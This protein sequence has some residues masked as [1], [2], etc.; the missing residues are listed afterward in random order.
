[1][2]CAR[3][4]CPNEARPNAKYCSTDCRWKTSNE[5]RMSPSSDRK[6]RLTRLDA[7]LTESGINAE[8]IGEVVKAVR[9]SEWQ[10]MSKDADGDPQ[11]TDLKATSIL[12]HPTWATGPKW[13]VVQPAAPVMV[14]VPK[15]DH[16][17]KGALVGTWKTALIVPDTQYGFRRD[18][19][20]PTV[21]DPFHDERALDVVKQVAEA[22]RPDLSIFLGDTLDFAQ[23]GKYRQE[24]AFVLTVQPTLNAA[25]TD[26]ATINEL[27]GE[28]RVIEGNHDLRLQNQTMDNNKAAFGIKRAGAP[29]EEWPVQS[30]P[31]L[32]RLDEMGIEYVGGY[33]AG[34][35]Y[36]NDNLACIHGKKVGNV[37]R[38][39][40]SMVVEDERVSVIF[41]HTHHHETRGRTRNSRGGPKFSIAHSPGCLCR[42][43]GAVPSTKGAIDAFGRAVRSW[44]D[45]QQ[46]C[47]IVRYQPGDGRFDIEQVEIFEGWAL[48]GGQEFIS[49]VIPSWSQAV[50]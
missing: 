29:P 10:V 9:V 15:R 20:D 31:H 48:H 24:E 16:S 23:F 32:L 2:P 7:L 34:A 33:P 37:T 25:Y 42:I 35:T 4:G 13:P 3:S 45:W 5:R 11:V 36:I 12:L 27:S 40:A 14:K 21:M 38:S 18:L 50:A 22:E 28:T 43:D 30:I 17:G 6:S 44:E 47:S 19:Y 49:R 46:G 41:G 26:I 8:D 1:M 39:A